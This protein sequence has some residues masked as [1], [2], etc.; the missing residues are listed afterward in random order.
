MSESSS[1]V[2]AE[3]QAMQSIEKAFTDLE[4]EVQARVLRWAA[5]RY[6]VAIT[7]KRPVG[8]ASEVNAEVP[9]FD[10]LAEFF[11]AAGPT[12]EPDR[13]LV[14]SYWFQHVKNEADVDA[15]KVNGELKH[16]GHG[17]SNITSALGSLIERKPQLMIQ[18]KK[19]GTSKQARKKYRVT[20]AGKN[21]VEKMLQQ[22]PEEVAA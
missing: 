16:L 7:G 12:T 14:V 4:A 3:I 22:Q 2:S 9:E 10:T 6:G 19:A 21:A 17:V 13:A 20:N 5:D 11:A 18:T 8:G 1:G 15:G